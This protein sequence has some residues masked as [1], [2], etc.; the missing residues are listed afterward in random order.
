MLRGIKH[1]HEH[2]MESLEVADPV[3]LDDRGVA[4]AVARPAVEV[5]REVGAGAHSR[6]ARALREEGLVDT[7][8][9]T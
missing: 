3:R 1:A 9:A 7:A 6:T 2:I 8:S 4:P 5:A